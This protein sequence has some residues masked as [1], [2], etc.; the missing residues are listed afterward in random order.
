MDNIHKNKE[1]I[2]VAIEASLIAKQRFLREEELEKSIQLRLEQEQQFQLQ[3]QEK[4]ESEEAAILAEQTRLQSEQTLEQLQILTQQKK[5]TLH[6]ATHTKEEQLF[7][8]SQQN[9][10]FHIDD[11]P[12]ATQSTLENAESEKIPEQEP[13]KHQLALSKHTDRDDFELYLQ[14]VNSSSEKTT[15]RVIGVLL[16][17]VITMGAYLV[18]Q[19]QNE[20]NQKKVKVNSTFKTIQTDTQSR[21]KD[22]FELKLDKTLG[23]EPLKQNEK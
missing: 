19:Y 2:K 14:K 22:L 21:P 5:Q 20:S 18:W 12:Y 16:F 13:T 11:L 3:L 10:L 1:N 23:L 17:S 9:S 6:N 15:N 8:A 7:E 4:L